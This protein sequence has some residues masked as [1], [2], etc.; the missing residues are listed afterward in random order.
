MHDLTL[1]LQNGTVTGPLGVSRITRMPAKLLEL[2]IQNEPNVTTAGEMK[3]ALYGNHATGDRSWEAILSVLKT[4]LR[5]VSNAKITN[6][7]GYGW[8]LQNTTTN[9]PK[10][11]QSPE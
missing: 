4:T 8:V 5:Q 1:D 7:Y 2:L 9:T 11:C 6:R 3:R 10:G